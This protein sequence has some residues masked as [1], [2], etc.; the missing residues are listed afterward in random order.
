MTSKEKV[1][2]ALNFKEESFIPKFIW[3]SNKTKEF[4]EKKFN[5][6]GPELEIYM[7]NDIL[8]TWL[9]IN[10]E[11]ERDVKDNTEFI[12]EWGITWKRSGNYNMV[13][14]HPLKNATLKNI[15]E[16]NLPNP[17]NPK[18]YEYFNFLINKYGQKYFIGA[19]ISG[20]IFE[21]SYHLMNMEDLL[22]SMAYKDEKVDLL[23]DKVAEFS[24]AVGIE[25]IKKGADWIWL[26]DDLGSQSGMIMSPDTWRHYLKPRMA[27]I[28]KTLRTQKSDIIIAY[29]SCGSMSDVIPDLIEIGINVLNPIQPLATNMDIYKIK[30]E[31]GS[32]ITLMG[33]ID[34]QDFMKNATPIEIRLQTKKLITNLKKGG[35]YIFAASHTIQPDIPIENILAM[36][37]ELKKEYK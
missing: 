36:V 31:Y 11:M 37:D 14:K 15:E 33:N 27:K 12:D 30:N 13:I 5:L 21:P 7:G 1:Y 4:L 19:D 2:N 25:A 23:F 16:Y 17:L 3:Y 28:I 24:T 22:I 9:S 18:R 10:G 8:Q 26:G 29:H 6:H 20:T 34:T 32:K 35:G